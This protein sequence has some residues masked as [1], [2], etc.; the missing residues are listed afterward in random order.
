MKIG[1]FTGPQKV[2][3]PEIRDLWLHADAGGY[4]SAWTWDHLVAL[5]G[6]LDDPHYE[7]W[8]LLAALA[9]LTTRL[10]VG[11]LVTANTFRHPG[12]LAKMAATLDH[13]TDGRLVVGL[14]AGY[15][16][17][18]HERYGL[19]LPPAAERA[20][21]LTEAVAVLQGMWAPGRFDF[22][23]RHYRFADAPCEPPPVGGSIPILIGGAGVR[24]MRLAAK[25]AQCWNLPDGQYGIDLP[26]LRDKVDALA[27]YCEEAGRDPAEIERSMSLTLFV[28]DDSRSLERRLSAFREYRGWDDETTRRHCVLGTP[29]AVVEQLRQF[30]AAGLDHF[31]IHLVP[32][33]NYGDLATFTEACLPHLR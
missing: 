7:G 21:M 5:H 17:E 2:S 8:T 6:T 29:E 24:T 10:Q 16:A 13:V 3:W 1:I 20:E 18:E 23:G 15:Y 12:L 25:A 32:G 9:A 27:R 33:V 31:M 22:E 11:H 4:D 30:E 19:R 28:D 26:R 14:G